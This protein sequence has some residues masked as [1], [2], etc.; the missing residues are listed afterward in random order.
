MGERQSADLPLLDRHTTVTSADAGLLWQSVRQYAHG[1][2]DADHAV[3]G[4][5]LGTDPPSGFLIT[6]EV[7]S[8]RIALNG[9]HRF[10]HYRLVFELED[11]PGQLTRLSAASYADFPGATGRL[12]R[13]LLMRTGGHVL[14]VRS[15]I[16][17]IVRRAV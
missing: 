15:M 14:A 1:L 11:G 2:A 7:E 10:A 6:D 9:N 17:A 5:I 3:L 13:T 12:Y 4:R 8:K 16:R